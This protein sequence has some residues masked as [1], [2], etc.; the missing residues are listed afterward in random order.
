MCFISIRM[1]GL[2]LVNYCWQKASFFELLVIRDL[3]RA[4]GFPQR[5]SEH[6]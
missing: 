2:P 1:N 3:I 5:L 4:A 6:G